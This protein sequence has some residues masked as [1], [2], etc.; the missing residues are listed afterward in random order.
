MYHTIDRMLGHAQDIVF[1]IANL[2]F[3]TTEKSAGGNLLLLMQLHSTV[4]L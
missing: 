3:I 4:G 2:Y 1:S